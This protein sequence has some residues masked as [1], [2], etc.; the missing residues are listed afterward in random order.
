ML[1]AGLFGAGNLGKTMVKLEWSSGIARLGRGCV[2]G[3]IGIS[4]SG[5]WVRCRIKMNSLILE[6][7]ICGRANNTAVNH[8]SGIISEDFESHCIS[9][10]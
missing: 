1:A 9:N 4:I 5:V 8:T 10:I 2:K 3:V 6:P 7:I